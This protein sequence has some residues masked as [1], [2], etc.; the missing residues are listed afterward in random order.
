[1]STKP[2]YATWQ[3]NTNPT[4]YKDPGL[5]KTAYYCFVLYF[6]IFASGYDGSYLSGLQA[7]DSWNAFFDTP[8]GNK[9]G[10][11]SASA[12]LPSFL[13]PPLI[14]WS[15]DKFGRRPV[16]LFGACGIIVGAIL[17]CFANGLAM[18]I[19]GRLVVGGCANFLSVASVCL[20]NEIVHPRLRHISVALF[21]TTYY[22]GSIVAAWVTFGCVYWPGNWGWRLPTLVQALGPAFML[23]NLWF[24]PESP[25]WLKAN[26][27]HDEA[28]LILERLHANGATNDEL[29]NN[30]IA[31][32]DTALAL[33]AQVATT[34]GSLLATKGN[35]K[36]M[37][38]ITVVALGSQWSGLGLIS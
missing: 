15:T 18:L 27:R 33:E 38:V 10:L 24:I 28:R 11:I 35:R 2:L 1:M 22:V 12:Y 4:W 9:L 26:H 19:V 6:A 30:E 31:E 13:T 14:A 36:R 17:G 16:I 32:I 34:W 7:L 23:A 37:V 8:A 21:L 29:V 25:R 20:L 3:N 5:K